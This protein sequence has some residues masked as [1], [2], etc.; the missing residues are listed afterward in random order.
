MHPLDVFEAFFDIV[1]ELGQLRILDLFSIIIHT[2]DCAWNDLVQKDL[3]HHCS[4]K[5]E[6]AAVAHASLPSEFY[7]LMLDDP[8]CICV[9]IAVDVFRNH[10]GSDSKLKAGLLIN[11]LLR[12]DRLDLNV[13]DDTSGIIGIPKNVRAMKLYHFHSA[14]SVSNRRF[15]NVLG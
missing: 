13:Q 1:V 6:T 15:E 4:V 3:Q 2:H 8:D 7:G 10:F 5:T 12:V 14:L 9:E 11:I